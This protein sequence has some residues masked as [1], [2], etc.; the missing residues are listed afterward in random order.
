MKLSIPGF[1]RPTLFMNVPG[2]TSTIEGFLKPIL[3]RSPIDLVV[4]APNP[5]LLNLFITEEE[6]P[7]IPDAKISG[8][9]N[10]NPARFTSSI[11]IIM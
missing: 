3:G 1:P 9:F 11:T 5:A 6:T 10:F 8:V 7:K 4:I 2:C